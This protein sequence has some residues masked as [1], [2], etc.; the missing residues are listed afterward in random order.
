MPHPSTGFPLRSCTPL[1]P[2][3]SHRLPSIQTRSCG[4]S[5]PGKTAPP[6]P[7]VLFPSPLSSSP[8]FISHPL[9]SVPHRLCPENLTLSLLRVLI[10]FLSTPVLKSYNFTRNSPFR[11][12]GKSK[13]LKK[14]TLKDIYWHTFTKPGSHYKQSEGQR[15]S[16]VLPGC[17]SSLLSPVGA[18]VKGKAKRAGTL[19]LN[20]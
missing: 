15:D 13:R 2:Y 8:V 4:P 12:E 10:L 18:A 1:P 3:V 14:K 20:V 11:L 19:A 16:I 5:L 9:P 17:Y 6:L 7:L